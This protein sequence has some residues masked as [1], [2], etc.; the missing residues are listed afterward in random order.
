MAEILVLAEHSG[1]TVK[2][3]TCELLTLARRFGEPA[4]VWTGPGA[5]AG[6][7]RLAEFGAAKV[8][9]AD[10]QEFDDYVVAPKAELLASLRAARLENLDE[11][12]DR[13]DVVRAWR[14]W[15]K[16]RPAPEGE[17][18]MFDMRVGLQPV[19]DLLPDPGLQLIQQRL[20]VLHVYVPQSGV[21]DTYTGL[22]LDAYHRLLGHGGQLVCLV[23]SAF[24]KAFLGGLAV[25]TGSV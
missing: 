4:V 3:V 12:I 23:Q 20:N 15:K 22:A 17:A 24:A 16:L 6:R 9:V 14:D 2:K 7:D 11:E 25:P 5:E 8:Y 19:V 13:G 10:G 18:R 21:Y 1:E